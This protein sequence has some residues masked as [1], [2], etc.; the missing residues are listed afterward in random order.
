MT[1]ISRPRV[2]PAAANPPTRPGGRWRLR[3]AVALS[4][5]VLAAACAHRSHQPLDI[6]LPSGH[7]RIDG[8]VHPLAIRPGQLLVLDLCA[9]WAP[10]CA[11]NARV[12]SDAR[13]LL[14]DAR[15]QLL[16]V[17]ILLDDETLLATAAGAYHEIYGAEQLVVGAGP[18]LR[19][20]ETVL[21]PVVAVPRLAVIDHEG[22]V[23]LDEM[24]AYTVSDSQDLAARIRAL[25]PRT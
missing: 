3:V 23:R 9:S 2:R 11:G 15:E 12:V 5:T 22:R 18:A 16:F 17:T 7:P 21:G 4:W 8:A 10:P 25:L 20:G 14:A 24:V 13:A 1:P 6:T 19:A